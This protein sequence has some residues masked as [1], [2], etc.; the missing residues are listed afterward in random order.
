MSSS[1]FMVPTY[2]VTAIQWQSSKLRTLRCVYNALRE[3]C[4]QEHWLLPTSCPVATKYV[5]WQEVFVILFRGR[6]INLYFG[7]S[8]PDEQVMPSLSTHSESGMFS[9]DN[10]R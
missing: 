5:H 7:F 6:Y 4:Y 10:R 9:L 8:Y 2:L 3:Q 1:Y